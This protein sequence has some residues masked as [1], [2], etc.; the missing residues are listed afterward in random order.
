MGETAHPPQFNPTPANPMR[1]ALDISR[2]SRWVD[3]QVGKAKGAIPAFCSV[4]ALSKTMAVPRDNSN[5]L[6]NFNRA[7]AQPNSEFP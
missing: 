4:F 7:A 3:M 2:Q 5:E 6:R 1:Q